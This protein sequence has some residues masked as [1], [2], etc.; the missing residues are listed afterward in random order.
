MGPPGNAPESVAAFRVSTDAMPRRYRL[1]LWREEFAAKFLRLAIEPRDP[2]HF[3]ADATIRILPGLKIA[4]CAMSASLWRRTSGMIDTGA[5]QIG[6]V[7]GSHAPAIFSR[8]GRSV[9]VEFGD[10]MTCPHSEPAD[11]SLPRAGR[12]VGLIVPRKSLDGLVGGDSLSPHRIARGSEAARLLFGY[13]GAASD[14]TNLASPLLSQAFVTH[15]YDLIAL[16]FGATR[17]GAEIATRRGLRAARLRAV[18]ADVRAN[19][20]GGDVSV[21]AVAQRHGITPRY[22]HMLF[23]DE[24]ATFSQF[25][26]WQRLE[27]ACNMLADPGH[28]HL[29]IAA[30]AYGAGFADLSHFNRAFRSRYGATPGEVRRQECP[31][32]ALRSRRRS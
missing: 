11:M 30:I 9:A 15:V 20:P 18:K 27:L 32:A 3:H 29:S 22:L 1:A 5:E 12:H 19:L 2:Q 4:S 8:R 10:L 17:D 26:L 24:G 25:V 28:D 31:P 16:A 13:V 7:L 6:V 23:E 21:A 14:E